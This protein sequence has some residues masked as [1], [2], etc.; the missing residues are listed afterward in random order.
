MC[1]TLSA[2]S[3]YLLF[4]E[5]GIK[6]KGFTVNHDNTFTFLDKDNNILILNSNGEIT[7]VR[8]YH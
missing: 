6:V 4:S 2:F 1:E 5:R 3:A 7:H 8:S